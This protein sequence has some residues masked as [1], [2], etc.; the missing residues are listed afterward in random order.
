[1]KEHETGFLGSISER[2]K[3]KLK[4]LYVIGLAMLGLA[5]WPERKREK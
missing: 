2:L 1:M 4:D 5:P 3:T